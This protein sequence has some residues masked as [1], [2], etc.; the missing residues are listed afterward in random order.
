MQ[1]Q[2]NDRVPCD[3]NAN[4]NVPPGEKD[5]KQKKVK[6]NASL[7]RRPMR[8]RKGWGYKCCKGDA[9]SFFPHSCPLSFF[10]VFVRS[11]YIHAT[12]SLISTDTPGQGNTYFPP[13]HWSPNSTSSYPPS[14]SRRAP[15]SPSAHG[16]AE[17][18][19]P[20]EGH[21]LDSGW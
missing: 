10:S 16:I 8:P 3:A 2:R 13:Q 20:R 19:S 21:R 1:M 7:V 5:E 18:L 6:R 11:S 14:D 17:T 15:S 4:A 9:S 12:T